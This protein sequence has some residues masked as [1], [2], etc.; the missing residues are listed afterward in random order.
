MAQQTI[1]LGTVA[2]DG[3]GDTLR[4]GGDKIN[5]NFTELYA[6]LTGLLDFK[7][8][9]DCSANPNYPAASKGDFYIVSVAGKIGGASGVVVQVLDAYF[10]KADNA[11]GTEAAVG[12]SWTVL[13]GNAVGSAGV[14]VEDEGVTETT[15]ATVLNFV[16]AGVTAADA[17]GGQCDITI[18]GGGGGVD[19]EDEGVSEATGATTLN[20]VGAGVVA[21]DMGGGVVDVTIAGGGSGVDVEDEGVSEA[22]G[23]STLNF[24]GAGV[25]ATD[26]GGGVVDIDIPGGGGAAWALAGTGQTATGVYDFAVDGAKLNIDFVGLGSFNEL[27]VIARDL[28]DGT[29]GQRCVQASVNN[30]S[31]FYTASGDY[32]SIS[33]T[34]AASNTTV[35]GLHDNISTAARTVIAH[36]RNLKGAAKFCSSN[37][38]PGNILFVASASDI[39]AIRIT[40]LGGGNI[41]GGTVRVYAR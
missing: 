18:P 4:D 36:V 26:M 16:G 33:T 9:T 7:G 41:T 35:L 3:T 39:N 23:A 32:I 22:T 28:T 15:A 27:L 30:G 25:T 10:A 20:F 2:N 34:G 40:N 38:S 5:D 1:N 8:S 31:S 6:G 24:I 12:T 17:G 14:D 11:G 29:S 37:H 13:Q 19:V 21:A